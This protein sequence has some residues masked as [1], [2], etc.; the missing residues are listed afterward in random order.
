MRKIKWGVLGTATIAK[1]Q[2]IPGMIKAENCELYAIAGRDI[3][4]ANKFKEEFGFTKAYGSYIELLEDPEVEAVYI[5]LPN[6]MHKEWAIKAAEHKKHILCEKPLSGN[7][8]DV[9][10]I[11]DVCDREG[12][13]LMEAFA[14]LH[15]P[16]VDKI[17]EQIDSGIVGEVNFIESCFYTHGYEDNIR[18]RRETYG[19]AIYDLGCYNITLATTLFGEMPVESKAVAHFSDAGIDETSTGYMIFSNN[20][21]AIFSCAMHPHSRG[22]RTFVYGTE[23]VIEIPI[24]FNAEGIQKWYVV[25][26]DTREEYAMDIPNN[27]MLEVE[28][29]GRCITDG[30]SPKVT[31]EFSIGYAEVMKDLLDSCGYNG[32]EGNI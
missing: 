20:R 31:H 30:E 5:P 11:I 2:T 19:G 17:K 18:I 21:R 28:Q 9:K 16:V 23:G 10:E 6:N 26:G 3:N 14:Y 15:S 1:G 8:D 22:D 4:K 24:A 32:K 7:P 25:K 12:V 29:L 27:Y 13:I